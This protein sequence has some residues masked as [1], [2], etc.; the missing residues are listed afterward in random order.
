MAVTSVVCL[1]QQ[2]TAKLLEF[3]AEKFLQEIIIYLCATFSSSHKQNEYLLSA[4][5]TKEMNQPC[6]QVRYSKR[7]HNDISS[8]L[9]VNEIKYSRKLEKV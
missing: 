2:F 4:Y 1:C 3:A 6:K 8:L 9:A 7:K 5:V